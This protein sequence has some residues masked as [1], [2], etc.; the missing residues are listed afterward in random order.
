MLKID[1]IEDTKPKITISFKNV[2]L[3]DTVKDVI[4]SLNY[5]FY[6]SYK[7]LKNVWAKTAYYCYE[8]FKKLSELETI[9]FSDKA[10]EFLENRYETERT[11]IKLKDDFITHPPLGDFQTEGIK[12]ALFQNRFSFFWEMGLGKTYGIAM[13]LN[14]LIEK[15]YVDKVLIV[16]PSEGLVNFR[17]EI[18]KFASFPVTKED[19]YMA[20]VFNREPFES[21]KRFIIM[22]YRTFLLLSDD[23]YFK[24]TGKKFKPSKTKKIYSEP[25]LPIEKWGKNRCI[26]LDES[27][28]IKQLSARQTKA[29]HLHKDFFKF[30]YLL[31]GTPAP[32]GANE[33]YSQ[34]CFLDEGIVGKSYLQFLKTIAKLGTNFSE[35]QIDYFYP[36]EV[37]K[38]MEKTKHWY[39]RELTKDNL[40]L[41]DLIVKNVYVELNS[42]Q[43]L[44]Y[45][46]LVQ[47]TLKL[48]RETNEGMTTKEVTQKF[49]YLIQALSDPCLLKK[50][51][52]VM[53]SDNIK[54]TIKDWK[55]EENSKL[56]PCSSL[57]DQYIKK[58]GR[59]VILWSGH[60]GT[61]QELSKYYKKYNPIII[62]GEMKT[63]KGLTRDE[64]KGNLIEEFQND[65]S[66]KL[67]ICSYLMVSTAINLVEA[68][69]SIYFDRGWNLV[70]YLQSRKRVH[71]Y[72]QTDNV[73]VNP[74]IIEESLEEIQDYA[75]T[76][77]DM[78]NMNFHQHE[79]LSREDWKN[80]FTGKLSEKLK[81][82]NTSEVF[83]GEEDG[84]ENFINFTY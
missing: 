18:I 26:I 49:P 5:S 21:D 15:E 54:K 56:D 48:L 67:L 25:T 82:D 8:D 55:F 1:F 12:K 7:G 29:I 80:I 63:P 62:H 2:Y 31:T 30:R 45:R 47:E 39:S 78:F 46:T 70:N 38:F 6:P 24:K 74:L 14:H 75:L 68:S 34:F 35:N 36:E 53:L 57:L 52:P 44:L 20:N 37:K 76:K 77:K 42:K 69:R 83:K 32:N 22:T 17:R 40:E 51:V 65:S 10:K 19:F 27:H 81:K 43:F 59:K 73:I 64:Y 71:R 13:T 50:D 23:Y 66:K 4:K 84:K 58:E 16:C 3:F 79:T 28:S 33:L 60:P 11:G 61:I 72:G 9:V 41:P